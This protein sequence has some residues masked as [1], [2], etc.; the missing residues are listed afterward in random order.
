MMPMIITM[1][2]TAMVR[3]AWVKSSNI[4]AFSLDQNLFLANPKSQVLMSRILQK[5][6]RRPRVLSARLIAHAKQELTVKNHIR[7]RKK[8][9]VREIS[10]LKAEIGILP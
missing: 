8:G 2:I 10:P 3:S 7:Q 1:N 5:A 4:Q 6:I 9:I